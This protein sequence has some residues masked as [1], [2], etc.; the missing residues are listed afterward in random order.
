MKIWI[1]TNRYDLKA[2]LHDPLFKNAIYL[3]STTVATSL[4][5]FIFWMIVA[6][7]YTSEEVG[8]GST[9]ISAMSL[10]SMLSLL[11]FNVAL[12]R[13]L[14]TSNQ[15]KDMINSC[16]TLSLTASAVITIIFL[17]GLGVFSPKLLF[18]RSNLL[19]ALLFITFTCV[20]SITTLLNS[21]LT[22]ERTAKYVLLKESIFG[23]SRLPIPIFLVS[24]GAFGIFVSWGIGSVIALIAGLIFLFHVIPAYKP[25]II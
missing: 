20:W 14:P 9:I 6:R 1:P 11:G 21:I 24:L 23:A 18:L 19:F 10:L 12:I 15:K 22:A 8:L 2:H 4:L 17:L 16:F 13:F 7:Y 5:G 25:A 3:I